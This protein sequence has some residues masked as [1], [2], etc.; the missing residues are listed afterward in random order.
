V[1]QRDTP[2]R[3][4]DVS[5]PAATLGGWL[6]QHALSLIVVAAVVAF[7]CIKLDPVTVA[8]VAVGLGLV[9]FI[10]EL[11]HFAA[12]KWCD[13]HVETFSIGF[14]PPLPGCRF[15]RGETVYQI[16]LV[17]LGGYVKMVGEGNEEDGEDDPRSFKNKTVGQR[18]MIISAGVIMN[19]FLAAAC[20]VGVYMTTGVDR[21]AGVIGSVDAG[22]PAWQ[23]GLRPGV[24]LL[25]IGGSDNPLFDDVMPEVMHWQPGQ[26]I[27]VKYE[28]FDGGN[29]TTVETQVVPRINKERGRPMI[30]IGPARAATLLPANRKKIPPYVPDT[31]AARAEPPLQNGDRVVGATDAN[32]SADAYN[33]E[34]VTELADD[35]R[36]PG[37]GRRDYFDLARRLAKW[38]GKEIVLV[39][40]HEGSSNDV[41]V[42]IPPAFQTSYGLRL[43]MGPITA[44]REGSAADQKEIRIRTAQETG[45]TIFEVEVA[46]A[47]GSF[48]KFVSDSGL[49]PAKDA[50]VAVLDPALLPDQ[51]RQWAARRG[52]GPKT[53]KLKLKRKAGHNEHG[54]DESVELPWDDNWRDEPSS[55]SSEG[56]PRAIDGLGLAYAVKT[57]IDEVQPGSPAAKAVVTKDGPVPKDTVY[58]LK[59]G[60]VIKA[61]RY[62]G[63]NADGVVKQAG[64]IELTPDQGAYAQWLAEEL[65]S[66]RRLGLVIQRGEDEKVE[67]QLEGEEDTARPLAARG[68]DFE[69]DMRLEKADS[70]GQ[71]FVMGLHHTGRLI[72]RIYQNLAAMFTGRISFPKNASGPIDIGAV[73]YAIADQNFPLFV[74][75]IG[76]ISVNLAVINFLPIPILDGG[77][78]VFL[79]YEKLRGRPAPEAIRV[80][81]TFIGLAM[82]GSLMAFVLFL[83][84]QKRL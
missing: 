67:V 62:F 51:L 24:Q 71:A 3:D 26:P 68:I 52:E 53:V 1:D 80:A 54:Q 4:G 16:A 41:K 69:Q 23:K 70:P 45:D 77:H 37:A 44:L 30:G 18:M 42:H 13:V 43:G 10:H 2:E 75:F 55:P 28:R 7:I 6:A 14:G 78:M 27:P 60:D 66:V 61:I 64:E 8:L 74:L 34:L 19:I 47:D 49:N 35:P 21:P 65:T 25:R 56:S 36:L 33:P 12:A 39:V 9:I 63:K 58:P 83:D 46:E 84:V 31:A 5:A 17:P 50:T 59:K 76:M 11:G 32:Q 40:R 82:I 20:F 29:T 79:I 15:Q 81:A 38:A 57:Q 72:S 48:R 73:A 22:S